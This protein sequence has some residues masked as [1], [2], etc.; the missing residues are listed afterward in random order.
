APFGALRERRRSRS[1]PGG[2]SLS[3]SD[4]A[5]ARA[6]DDARP[7]PVQGARSA[8]FAALARHGDFRKVGADK[9]LREVAAARDL[10]IQLRADI[11]GKCQSDIPSAVTDR[12]APAGLPREDRDSNVAAACPGLKPSADGLYD[13]VAA[14]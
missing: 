5:G 1:I 14:P 8:R 10:Q 12:D 3:E 13:D 11:G 4:R 2:P 9:G 6:D 7:A